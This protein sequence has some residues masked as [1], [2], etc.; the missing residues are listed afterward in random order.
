MFLAVAIAG[1][2]SR[3]SQRLEIDQPAVSKYLKMLE[4]SIGQGLFRRHGRSASISSC[5]KEVYELIYA[6]SNQLDGVMNAIK[7]DH[8]LLAGDSKIVTVHTLNSYF[9]ALVI[10]GV[11]ECFPI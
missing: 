9:V 5:S 7:N 6:V 2:L 8:R 11:I 10:R 4:L 3:A 1:L